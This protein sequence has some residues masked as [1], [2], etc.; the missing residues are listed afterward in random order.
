MSD[1]VIVDCT[2]IDKFC[3]LKCPKWEGVQWE[4]RYGVESTRLWVGWLECKCDTEQNCQWHNKNDPAYE[5]IYCTP[6]G[7][8]RRDEAGGEA[9]LNL[10]TFGF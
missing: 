10:L 3:P 8:I 5:Y 1:K 4:L 2:D 7:A 9:P 6:P